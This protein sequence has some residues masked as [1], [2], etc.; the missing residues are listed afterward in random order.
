MRGIWIPGKGSRVRVT[1]RVSRFDRASGCVLPMTYCLWQAAGAGMK[2]PVPASFNL[3]T[4]GRLAPV[5]CFVTFVH[6]CQVREVTILVGGWDSIPGLAS[7]SGARPD[8]CAGPTA[9][10]ENAEHAEYAETATA[11]MGITAHGST[12]IGGA[13]LDRAPF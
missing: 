9:N 5:L 12:R 2:T 11:L 7:E 13:G 4:Q 8:S 3:P 6:P 10:A 1:G